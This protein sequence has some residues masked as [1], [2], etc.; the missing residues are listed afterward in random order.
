M[1][2]LSVFCDS[3][4]A[5]NASGQGVG[6]ANRSRLQEVMIAQCQEESAEES[7]DDEDDD[8]GN[9]ND[10]SEESEDTEYCDYVLY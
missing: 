7:N 5:S 2:I 10:D 4:K 6:I 8:E 1:I 3:F 9:D